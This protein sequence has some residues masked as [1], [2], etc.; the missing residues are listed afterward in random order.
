MDHLPVS[1]ILLIPIAVTVLNMAA[2]LAIGKVPLGYNLRN[3]VVRWSMSLSTAVAFALVIG[4]LT[5]MLA[6]VNGM[7]E[8]TAGSGH[9]D[10][11]IALSDGSNDEAFSTLVFSDASDVDFEPGVMK[12][13][14]GTPLV[15]K[16]VYII[17][18]MPIAPKEGRSSALQ[19]KG[20]V[21]KIMIDRSEFLLTDEKGTDHVFRLAD[22]GQVFANGL[23]GKLDNLKPGDAVWLAYTERG[24]E[25]VVSEVQGSNRRRFVQVRGIEDPIV[26]SQVHHLDLVPGGEWFSQEG[27]KKLETKEAGQPFETAIQAVIGGGVARELGPELKKERLE[28]EDVFELGS[29]K[30]KVV[31]IMN[32]AG[33][34]FD[35]E[36]WAKRSYVGELYGKPNTISSLTI[37]TAS[38]DEASKLAENLKTNFKKANLQPYTETEYYSKLRGINI[39]LL[40]GIS[41]LTFWMAIGGVFGVM[42]TMFAAI[43]HRTKDIGVLRILGYTRR[44]ILV[45]F[46]LE[47]LV[48]AL[49]GGLV[50]CALGSL[51]HG[52]SATSI[53][54]SG[55]GGFGK[56]VIFRLSVDANTL[57][58]GFLLT[59]FMGSGGGLLPAWTAMRLKPLESLR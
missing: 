46:L 52:I 27:V 48:I 26:A 1:A 45:S 40:I 51:F 55:Q 5:V 16:E 37:R 36:V 32:S 34:T 25:R 59:L 6:F 56:T 28:V 3:L 54:G 57:A 22:D 17:A 42:N 9:A 49:V 24:E 30:W 39:Q 10:N 33:T 19:I 53:V 35:S 8:L 58:I 38:P 2:L 44:Q 18:S 31:G 15:S 47:S 41:F 4:L 13:A 21:R 20:H 43:S 29:K 11:V 23:A 50:G 12:S 14:A 7:A